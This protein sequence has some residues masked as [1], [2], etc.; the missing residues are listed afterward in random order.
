M[1]LEERR[2]PEGDLAI[3]PYC[4]QMQI[5]DNGL[6]SPLMNTTNQPVTIYINETE[7]TFA[8]MSSKR[9]IM[10]Y[11]DEA[12]LLAERSIEE[13]Q[14]ATSCSCEWIASGY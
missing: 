1:K 4:V 8:S 12:S 6:A 13:R 5:L 9:S 7:P 11:A 3:S 10:L 2:I 14:S